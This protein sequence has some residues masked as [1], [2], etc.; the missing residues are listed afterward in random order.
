MKERHSDVEQLINRV[1]NE[2]SEKWNVVID[3]KE[4]TTKEFW[5]KYGEDYKEELHG[6]F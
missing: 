2:E 5:D 4:I 6:D 1:H 3:D